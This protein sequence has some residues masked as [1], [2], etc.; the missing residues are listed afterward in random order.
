MVL[1]NDF[2]FSEYHVC[3]KEG[4]SSIISEISERTMVFDFYM[5]R[6]LLEPI[7]RSIW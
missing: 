2:Y 6:L 4:F 1:N 7:Q 3:E 5:V